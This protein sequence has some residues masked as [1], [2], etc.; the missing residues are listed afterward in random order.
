MKFTPKQLQELTT[1]R[2]GEFAVS[3][4]EQAFTFCRRL[5]RSHYENFPVGSLLIPRAL[6]PHFFS[7][8]AFSRIADDIADELTGH[9]TEQL[10]MLDACEHLLLSNPADLKGNPVFIA[11]H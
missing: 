1:S 4:V 8:Y 3:S 7:V 5:A 10:A 6:Q 9:T 11:L 2:G